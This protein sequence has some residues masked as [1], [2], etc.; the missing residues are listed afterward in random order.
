M[1]GSDS[2]ADASVAR[3]GG[4]L[5]GWLE[6]PCEQGVHW[7]DGDRWQFVSYRELAGGV[8]AI[9]RLLRDSAT[10]PGSIVALGCIDVIAFLRGLFGALH[11]GAI[12][13]ALPPHPP[14]GTSLRAHWAALLAASHVQTILCAPALAA[15]A[16]AAAEDA[17]TPSARILAD[18]DDSAGPLKAVSPSEVALLQYSSGSTRSPRAIRITWDNVRASVAAIARWQGQH[19]GVTSASWLPWHHD[20]GLI[21][22]LLQAVCLQQTTWQMRPRQ[23]L[24]DP[25]RWLACFGRQGATA[26]MVPCF[27]LDYVARRVP[28]AALDAMDFSGVRSIAVGAE[29][30]TP[31]A[32]HAFIRLLS[33][34]GL[35]PAALRPAYGLAEAT[36]GVTATTRPAR[37][38]A[39]DWTAMRLGAPVTILD[40]TSLDT[41]DHAR[42]ANSLVTCGPPMDGVDV[43]IVASDGRPLG[44]G[45]LGEI[46]VRG[47]AVAAGY[48]PQDSDNDAFAD[49][50]LRTG[51]A[52]F[53]VDRELVVVGRLSDSIKVHGVHVYMESL[54][55]LIAETIAVTRNRCVALP[56]PRP[57]GAD[58]VT[59]L[60]EDLDDDQRDVVAQCLR[61]ALGPTTPI[62][63]AGVA[64]GAILHTTS[65]KPRRRA[66]WERLV[67][68]ASPAI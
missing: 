59:A 66:M 26:T 40:M 38:V 23:F 31:R 51:D 15:T 3:G 57:C 63:V 22:S 50:A 56:D 13:V 28:A 2:I 52:G 25:V 4:T 6:D 11:A 48:T 47:R 27:A 19:P 30:V 42:G 7:L 65:G 45:R 36:L 41:P 32:L 5:L 55:D 9:S 54:E 1:G 67:S 35:D 37:V 34:R 58:G 39:P 8:F 62:Q 33:G 24:L 53:T 21:G 46:V 16:R 68:E 10:A 64:R 18:V 20:M 43:D 14:G 49:G 60:V 44:D 17:G 29:R 12:A 61:H